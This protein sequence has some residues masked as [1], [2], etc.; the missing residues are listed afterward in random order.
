MS[1]TP[2]P[3][4]LPNTKLITLLESDFVAASNGAYPNGTFDVNLDQQLVLKERDSIV[5][6]KAFIDTTPSEETFI[7]ITQ[8]ET[9]ITI[10]HGMYLTD[11]LPN[12]FSTVSG[13]KETKKPAWGNWST[14]I[15]NR[16]DGKKYILQN[17]QDV[18]NDTFLDWEQVNNANL[19]QIVPGGPAPPAPG[20]VAQFKTELEALV[21][22]NNYGFE[23]LVAPLLPPPSSLPLTGSDPAAPGL[24]LDTIYYMGGHCR[25][26]ATGSVD[27]YVGPF[28]FYYYHRSFVPATDNVFPDNSHTAVISRW[29]DTA[30]N[31]LGWKIKGNADTIE[32]TESKKWLYMSDVDGYNYFDSGSKSHMIEI[33]EVAMAMNDEWRA[34]L[35]GEN[36]DP[37]FPFYPAYKISWYDP[38][39]QE[40]Y[41]INKTFDAQQY[42]P[43]I[44]TS[45]N[46]PSIEP[47]SGI[48]KILDDLPNSSKIRY[49]D[50]P[51]YGLP[52]GSG[53]KAAGWGETS[54][55]Q[56]YRMTQ[57][58][59]PYDQG[60]SVTLPKMVVSIDHMPIIEFTRFNSNGVGMGSGFVNTDAVGW[61]DSKTQAITLNSSQVLTKLPVLSAATGGRTFTPREYTTT[62][63][64][65]AGQYS[66]GDLAQILTDKINQNTSPVIGLSNNP[67]GEDQPINAAGY[68]SSYF[69]QT[70]YELM[71]QADGYS[72][73]LGLPANLTRYPN[74]YVFRGLNT[75]ART[76]SDGRVLPAITAKTNTDVNVQPYFLAEDASEL[77][78]F[79]ADVVQPLSAANQKARNVGASQVSIIF[80][81]TQ[82]AFSIAQA[83]TNIVG[84]G[85]TG[86][87]TGVAPVIQLLVAPQDTVTS[88]FG[89]QLACDTYSG[90]FFTSL[91]PTSLWFEKMQ[92]SKNILTSRGTGG[93]VLKD[94]STALSSSFNGLPNALDM[95]SVLCHP[96]VLSKG[97]N[98]TGLF[99]G[100]DNLVVKKP[101]VSQSTADIPADNFATQPQKYSEI[102][103]TDTLV[104]LVGSSLVDAVEDDPYYQIEIGGINSQNIVGQTQKN[105]LVQAIVGKFYSNGNFTQDESGGYAYTHKGEPLVIKGLS[106][107]ILNSHGEPE[108]GLG[109]ASAF[110]LKVS[111]DK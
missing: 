89:N 48:E 73:T 52:H 25:L 16:P 37:N 29:T 61:Y 2:A 63:S 91:E 18:F 85:P 101:A 35:K 45:T 41:T 58:E 87:T 99:N 70:S 43:V 105:N 59:D 103:E 44:N 57:Y 42:Y 102:V 82:Q 20:T 92:L 24:V 22:A 104:S 69:F 19:V 27:K 71:M 38:R 111:T 17:E 64:I 30:G 107:R 62:F 75:P 106:V 68:S 72:Q 97:V 90:I 88:F 54:R 40:T 7:T 31:I 76:L 53:A 5:L 28:E 39:T 34:V 96:T 86:S 84:A 11:I 4:L 67:A 10:K 3:Q 9:E 6:D 32:T 26:I 49:E 36:V 8:E 66:N 51:Q 1:E 14:A 65:P 80:D 77:F 12:D 109:S 33:G 83:H 23:Y 13:T 56:F 79:K 55:W 78:Q 110:V 81:E 21:P 15:G 60:S 108:A 46:P 47:G 100:V 94:F 50:R 93:T 98:I 95:S 74:D